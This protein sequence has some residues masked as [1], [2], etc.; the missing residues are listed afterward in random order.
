LPYQNNNIM[1]YE[2]LNYKGNDITVGYSNCTIDNFEIKEIFYKEVDV[3]EL[4]EFDI[5]YINEL[6]VER[7]FY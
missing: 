5:D 7:L 1:N 3:Y 2:N 6:L 4:L